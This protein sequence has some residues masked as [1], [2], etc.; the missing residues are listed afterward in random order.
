MTM[1]WGFAARA[2]SVVIT[3][4]FAFGLR[5]S[6]DSGFG[7]NSQG[8]AH[9]SLKIGRHGR[10]PT[11]TIVLAI[12]RCCELW[13]TSPLH[14]PKVLSRHP[15]F[16]LAAAVRLRAQNTATGKPW[17]GADAPGR[18]ESFDRRDR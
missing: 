10:F 18:G 17:A 6:A 14:E 13:C 12:F 15:R 8:R 7:G 5:V 2:C 16:M 11:G 3:A 4:A 1:R 9:A